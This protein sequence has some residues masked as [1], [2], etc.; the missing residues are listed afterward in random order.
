[1]VSSTL[2][3]MRAF[4][5][6]VVAV[7]GAIELVVGVDVH[8]V[9]AAEQAFAPAREE[10]AVAVEHDH[11]MLAAVE[12]IDAVLAVDGDRGDVVER[13]AVRQL[14]PVLDHAV[15]ML[16]GA[17]N[18]WHVVSLL[19]CFFVVRA[20]NDADV[21]P[22]F[23]WRR[24]AAA[25]P[26]IALI[27]SAR[28]FELMRHC[29]RLPAMNHRP[30]CGVRVYM[31]R[32]SCAVAETPDRADAVGDVLA[33]QFAHQLVPGPCSRSPARSDR[34]RASRRSSSARLRRQ[35]SRYRR[36]A[37]SPI[38]PLTIRSEQPTLK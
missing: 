37:R 7:V 14:R 12:D 4:A 1:M 38:S 34:R 28:Y 5:H 8:A 19:K 25:L 32:N 30:G 24:A 11:R 10:I 31:L 36:T 2:P 13:P 26:R 35:S 16:A 23:D 15:A 29:A 9:R 27:C 21:R 6:G 18:G 20:W 3:S 17:E 33:E 22:R